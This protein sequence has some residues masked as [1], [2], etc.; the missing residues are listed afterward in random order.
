MANP[1]TYL[2][3]NKISSVTYIKFQLSRVRRPISMN[4]QMQPNPADEDDTGIGLC[5]WVLTSLSL[6]NLS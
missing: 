2:Y 4:D 6:G 5:G 3:F 1:N